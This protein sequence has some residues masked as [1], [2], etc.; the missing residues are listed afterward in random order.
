[1]EAKVQIYNIDYDLS[2]HEYLVNAERILKDLV[3]SGHRL[4]KAHLHGKPVYIVA[5]MALAKQIFEDGANFSFTAGPVVQDEALTEGARMFVNQGLESPL[6]ASSYDE[7][8]E[9]RNLFNQAFK[10][11]V[12]DRVE[13][14]RTHAKKHIAGLLDDIQGAQVD[15]LALCRNYW[16]PLAAD[17]IGLG[18]LSIYELNLLAASV[19]MVVEANGLHNDVESIESLVKANKAIVDLIRKVIDAKSAPS[20]SALGFLLGEF[21]VERAVDL[22]F[23]FVLGGI[24]TGS[25]A[26][27]LQ[28]YLLAANPEQCVSF[29]ALSELEQQGAITELASKEAP[30]YYT[31][32]FAVRDVTI[33][34]IN[35]AAGSFLHLAM[36]GLNNCANPDFDI[37]RNIK[38]SCPVHNNETFPFGHARH[39]CPGEALARHLIPIFLNAFFSR[40]ELCN[41]ISYR[42]DLNSFSRS[43]SEFIVQVEQK[44]G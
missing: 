37:T 12:V 25:N 17:I 2:S 36:H 43:V 33:S 20:H 7:Y 16:M 41:I 13:Q 39:R 15:V 44:L 28:T 18:S 35:I 1:M 24:D 38:S 29:I 6:L 19:R 27:A 42:R 21:G 9:Q 26:L 23:S 4:A 14:I 11:S 8:R 32:R 5:D 3:L 34:G 30:A 40:F 10:H 31:P 22:T